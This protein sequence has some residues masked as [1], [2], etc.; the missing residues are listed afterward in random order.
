MIVPSSFGSRR[1]NP[2]RGMR[3]KARG[4]EA[5]PPDA[6]AAERKTLGLGVVPL[7][8]ETSLSSRKFC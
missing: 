2:A 8:A 6:A 4:S 5:P 3:W 1:A 7:G